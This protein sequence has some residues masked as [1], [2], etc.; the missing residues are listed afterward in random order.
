[1]M[2]AVGP[3]LRGHSMASIYLV[4]AAAACWAVQDC[5][6]LAAAARW[7][8]RGCRVLAAAA[9][10]QCR[11]AEYWLQLHI[12]QCRAARGC[13]FGGIIVATALMAIA[14]Q[15]LR[16]GRA[17]QGTC[18]VAGAWESSCG[19]EPGVKVGS[20]KGRV[21]CGDGARVTLSIWLLLRGS[22]EQGRAWHCCGAGA[23]SGPG[24]LSWGACLAGAPCL[25]LP[26]CFVALLPAGSSLAQQLLPTQ[27]GHLG[28]SSGG[29][30]SEPPPGQCQGQPRLFSSRSLFACSAP[31]AP[32]NLS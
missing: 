9:R 28:C 21:P 16:K 29:A 25:L 30:H 20:T 7:A 26:M 23:D 5:T 8:V 10:C 31:A 12:G 22:M 14:K 13:Q 27:A 2:C 15:K 6:G 18:G 3:A 11:A 19:G 17:A 1:M 4:L 24:C 32:G